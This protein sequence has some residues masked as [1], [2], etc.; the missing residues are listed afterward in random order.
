MFNIQ[1]EEIASYGGYAY[2]VYWDPTTNQPWVGP[3]AAG[4]PT[5]SYPGAQIASLP[6]TIKPAH[7]YADGLCE[8]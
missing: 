6:C 3:G 1:V 7:V 2:P 4:S 5:A 8:S